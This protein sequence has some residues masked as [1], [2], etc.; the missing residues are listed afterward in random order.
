MTIDSIDVSHQ[1]ATIEQLLKTEKLSPTMLATIQMLLL[2]VKLMT[3]KLG[4]NS[5][6][7]SKAPSTD[8][9]RKK[10]KK[11]SNER[12]VGGQQGHQG[13][14]LEPVDEPDNIQ[15]IAFDTTQKPSM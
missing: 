5:R 1:I 9:N 11:E 12:K 14:R 2:I 3:D 10:L 7:S 4:L 6:N 15:F 13:K 8:L